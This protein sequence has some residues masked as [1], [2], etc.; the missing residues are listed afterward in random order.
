MSTETAKQPTPDVNR[1]SRCSLPNRACG[2][3]RR[4]KAKCDMNP[5]KCSLCYRIGSTCIYPTTRKARR[6]GNLKYPSVAATE[7]FGHQTVQGLF[8]MSLPPDAVGVENCPSMRVVPPL[9]GWDQSIPH[10]S[11]L[12]FED[13]AVNTSE[14]DL[15]NAD[16]GYVD[17]LSPLLGS[18]GT[19][20]ELGSISDAGGVQETPKPSLILEDKQS[21]PDEA[22]SNPLSPSSIDISPVL[23]RDLVDRFFTH[24]HYYLPLFHQ[25]KFRQEHANILHSSGK[26]L[27]D[28]PVQTA[29]LLCGIFAL[30]ARFS[31]VQELPSQDPIHRGD[32][33]AEQASRLYEL[34]STQLEDSP[35]SLPHLQATILLTFFAM[36]TS[37]S[38]QAWLRSSSCVRLAFEMELHIC[39]A[40]IMSGETDIKSLSPNEFSLREERRR[41][42]WIMWDMDT[43][44]SF[45]ALRPSATGN[46]KIQALLPF[47]DHVWASGNIEPSPY[48]EFDQLIPWRKLSEQPNQSAWAWF[49][50]VTLLSRE[51]TD[52]VISPSPSEKELDDLL[53]KFS[54]YNLALPESFRIDLQPAWSNSTEQAE[55]MNWIMTSHLIR[56]GYV[57]SS[58]WR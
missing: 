46:P 41:A 3:C 20:Q 38:R 25:T 47:P 34:S 51:A 14:L 42:W 8:H 44:L 6:N 16:F 13:N 1:T 27:S 50:P 23:A 29:F 52:L 24:V 36:Q 35:P 5:S 4:K 31:V 17:G 2:E 7:S 33:F 21:Q 9:L 28:L 53:F 58:F 54:C 10:T 48:L 19:N 30:S 22:N 37:P 49:L 12:Q 56:Q 18:S 57:W 39:D 45:M 55:G 32:R 43:F 40:D 15:M 26:T 11:V